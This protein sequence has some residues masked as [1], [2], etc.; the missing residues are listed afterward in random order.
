MLLQN[1]SCRV[2]LLLAASTVMVGVTLAEPG[3]SA[4][5]SAIKND[6]LIE[7]TSGILVAAHRGHHVL[8]PENSLSSIKSAIAVRVDIVELDVRLSKD[9]VPIL[10]HDGTVDRTTNGTG[11][12]RDLTL[13]ELKLLRLKDASGA[14]TDERIPTLKEALDVARGQIMVDNDLKATD[15]E[16]ILEVILTANMIDQVM[17][18]HS[19]PAI[20]NRVR[21]I[22]PDALVMPIAFEES[23]I[24]GLL[25]PGDLKMLHI[26]ETYNSAEIATLL[27]TSRIA[28]WT[29]ALGAADDTTRVEGPE[30]GFGPVVA[31]RPD[32]I[33]TDLPGKLVQYLKSRGAHR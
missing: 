21:E 17:F 16:P 13:A 14:L 3:S 19:D 24:V 15:I 26:L 4:R 18:F 12:V 28:G 29:N 31:N 22:A 20:L 6:L 5:I 1:L 10:M 27:D 7:H 25:K 33:Q 32:V 23:G 30:A 2:P 8:R 11:A 9:R